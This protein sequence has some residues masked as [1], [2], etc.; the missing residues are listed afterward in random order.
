[1]DQKNITRSVVDQPASIIKK[2]EEASE[3][4]RRTLSLFWRIVVVVLTIAGLSLAINEVFLLRLL[5]RLEFENA[6]IYSLIASL[7]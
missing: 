4:P 7:L 1:M 6:Y 2:S 3:S 5:G